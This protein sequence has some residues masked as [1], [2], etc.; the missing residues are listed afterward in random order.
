MFQLYEPISL[1][2]RT[3][4]AVLYNAVGAGFGAG[5]L[6]AGFS[7]LGFG[8]PRA[9]I[10]YMTAISGFFMST[11]RGWKEFCALLAML[12]T[13]VAYFATWE[14]FRLGSSLIVS[15][16]LSVLVVVLYVAY[17]VSMVDMTTKMRAICLA[18]QLI[19]SPR[20]AMSLPL[21]D[22]E[23][24]L[25]GLPLIVYRAMAVA[26]RFSS[27]QMI[28][29]LGAY[30]L[31]MMTA[32]LL[33]TLWLFDNAL[34][35][36]LGASTSVYQLVALS[37][38]ARFLRRVA[39]PSVEKVLQED[40]R[41]PI[42]FLRPFKLDELVVSVFSVGWRRFEYLF[43][44]ERQTFE[45]YLVRAFSDI[46]PVI[47]IG[48]PSEIAAPIGAAREY[49]DDA[50]WQRRVLERADV[51]RLV[52]MV[53]DG[54]PGMEWEIRHVPERVKLRRIVAVLP[55]GEEGEAKRSLEWYERWAT[56][57]KMFAFL[58][59]VSENTIAVLFDENDRPIVVSS[60]AASLQERIAV[61]K[62]E[63]LKN[64]Q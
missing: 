37:R 61:I 2:Q 53:C 19:I 16:V 38:L 7:H 60:N 12:G 5:L 58:P 9:G 51:A 18:Q 59:E 54:T 4:L 15:T 32:G 3:N 49:L 25:L 40:S 39:Q 64:A 26:G 31:L 44:A 17:V 34:L 56:L 10:F 57:R 42:L 14:A 50:S 23:Q 30:R 27:L 55:F 29:C 43:S 62:A 46:G 1:A 13:F 41:L 20:E 63:W 47:A 33:S 45:E 28:I 35:V 11:I 22:T 24:W 48:R 8:G 52:I 6:S 21:Q 36:S